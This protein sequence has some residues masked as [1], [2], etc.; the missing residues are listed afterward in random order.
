MNVSTF[1]MEMND[2]YT[3]FGF[4]LSEIVDTID[5]R[6]SWADMLDLEEGEEDGHE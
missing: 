1:N 5:Q 3:D 4:G 6:E 2:S